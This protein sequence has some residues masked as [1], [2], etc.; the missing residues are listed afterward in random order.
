MKKNNTTKAI[1]ADRPTHDQVLPQEI[2]R[3][4]F[5]FDQSTAEQKLMYTRNSLAESMH[6]KK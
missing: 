3:A 6:A 5:G 4:E 2:Q 1:G